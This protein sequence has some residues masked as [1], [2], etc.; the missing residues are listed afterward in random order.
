[1]KIQSRG[2][3]THRLFWELP[4]GA[5]GKRRQKTETFRGS[6][7][8]AKIRWREEQALIDAGTAVEPSRMT[9]A[10]LATRWERDVLPMRRPRPSTLASYESTLRLHILPVLGPMLVQKITAPDV[11]IC[12]SGMQ[13]HDGR[14]G[15]P[16]PRQRQLVSFLIGQLLEQAVRWRVVPR[17]VAD[18]TMAPRQEHP[19]IDFWDAHDVTAFLATAQGHRLYALFALALASGMRRGE[20]LGLRREEVDFDKGAVT[21][22]R[23]LAAVKGRMVETPP[24]TRRGY[25]TIT[26]GQRTMQVLRQHLAAMEEERSAAGV[27]SDDSGKDLCFPSEA[28]TPL[29]ARNVARAFDILQKRAQVKRITLHG[30]RHTHATQLL[31]AGVP[32]HVVSERLGHS[33]VAFT[34]QIYG[35]VLPRQEDAAAR[36]SDLGGH[37]GDHLPLPD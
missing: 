35:H 31:A 15:E 1:M 34:L 13:R 7:K 16:S 21:V 5:D 26:V 24:K 12:I 11:Q 10:D 14:P 36:F 30:L 37:F 33:S 17:N 4:R 28:G 18:D 25:R 8:D 32:P 27:Y 23:S 6:K 29:S 3:D 2:K 19:E 20:I 9:F 22:K